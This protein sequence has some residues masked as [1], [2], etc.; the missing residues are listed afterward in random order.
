MKLRKILVAG[1]VAGS[2]TISG[3]ALANGPSGS[4]ESVD[5]PNT[6]ANESNEV[7]CGAGTEVRDGITVYAGTNGV[8]T[9]SDSD[10]AAIQGR[11]IASN[12]NGGYVAVDGDQDNANNY[13]PSLGGYILVNRNAQGCGPTG[14][15]DA[16]DAGA[17]ASPQNCQPGE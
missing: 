15:G 4:D 8:E 16:S 10:A 5:D 12:E 7:Q 11:V 17:A 1:L 13:D 6:A 3:A 9:C 14:G 2:M